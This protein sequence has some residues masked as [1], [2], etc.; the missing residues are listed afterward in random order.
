MILSCEAHSPQFGGE[1]RAAE[2]AVIAGDVHLARRVSIWHGAVL[3]GDAAPIRIGENTNIQDNAV[4][5]V[6]VDLPVIV[7][8]NVTVGHGAIIHGC[9]VGDACIVG[10][11]AVLLDGCVIGAGSLVGAGALVTPKTVIPP[12]SVC[13]GAPAKAARAVTDHDRSEIQDMYQKYM[14]YARAELPVASGGYCVALTSCAGQ[15]DAEALARALLEERL[16][17]CVQLRPV[18]SFYRWKGEIVGES[19]VQLVIKCRRE[20]FPAVREAVL[21]RHTYEVPE[22]VALPIVDGNSEYLD[23]IDEAASMQPLN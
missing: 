7:G 13:L 8:K 19:E 15:A 5:H 21:R 12:G 22:L 6:S 3:R 11:G 10:M 20:A 9:T 23:W 4:V 14:S 17:A 1:V 16:A 2:S 18:S